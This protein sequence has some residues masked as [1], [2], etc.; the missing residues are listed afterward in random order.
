MST[1]VA[2]KTPRR[3]SSERASAVSKMPSGAATLGKPM[4]AAV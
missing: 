3:I 2:H 4:M 1:R